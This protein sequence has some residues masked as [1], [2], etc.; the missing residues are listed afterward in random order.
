MH[1]IVTAAVIAFVAASGSPTRA[2]ILIGGA[3]PNTGPLAWIGE[4][5][6]R[7]AE[8]VWEGHVG[9]TYRMGRSNFCPNIRV[10][11]WR[12]GIRCHQ[13]SKP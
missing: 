11:S 5:M 12:P 3:G 10:C 6:Q 4:Q 1:R 9:A 2:E 13:K 7:G 8:M